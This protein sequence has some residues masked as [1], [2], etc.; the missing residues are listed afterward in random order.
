MKMKK[1]ENISK[2]MRKPRSWSMKP[3]NSNKATK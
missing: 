2:S 3:P 1:R